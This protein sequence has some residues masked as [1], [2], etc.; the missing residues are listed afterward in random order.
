MNKPKTHKPVCCTDL[1]GWAASRNSDPETSAIAAD[2]VRGGLANELE[3]K[4]LAVL[5][6]HSDGLTGQEVTD[7]LGLDRVTT[8][9]RF[10]PLCR[11]RLI[12]DSGQRRK[13]PSGRPAIVW[14]P[15]NT[16]P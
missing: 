1:F 10:A 12:F 7:I 8:S 2:S 13:G 3:S 11:K 6:D 16:K 14:K 4:V 9:P 5:K 15:N